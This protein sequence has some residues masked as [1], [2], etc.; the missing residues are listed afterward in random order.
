MKGPITLTFQ[1]IRSPVPIEFADFYHTQMSLYRLLMYTALIVL[2]TQPVSNLQ[3]DVI[4]RNSFGLHVHGVKNGNPWP[5]VPFGFIRLWDSNTTWREI[6]PEKGSW[7]FQVLD[8]YVQL[9]ENAGVEVLLTLGQTPAW[10]ALNPLSPSPYAAGASSPPR[11]F[12]D[13][14]EYV[15]ALA[16]RYKGRIRH[17]EVWNEINVKHFWSG[18]Y[19][20]MVRMEQIAAVAFKSVDPDNFL[21]SPSIQGGGYNMLAKYFA[22]GGGYYAD[23]V[24]YHFYAPKNEPEV[25][26]DR[27]QRVREIMKRYGLKNKPLWNTEMGWLLANRDGGFGRRQRPEWKDWRKVVY[28]ETAGF[29]MRAYLIN[30]ANGIDHIFW[31]A[32]NNGAMGLAEDGGRIIKPGALSYARLYSWLE[33]VSLEECS[34]Y[35]GVW[36][37]KLKRGIQSQYIL[38]SQSKHSF[39]VPN[40]WG[41]NQ[42]MRMNGITSALG[43]TSKLFIGPEPVLLFKG[44]P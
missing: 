43:L 2:I 33:G 13:W 30:M 1:P 25:L 37:V 15:I 26:G 22:A 4:H 14:R 39:Q 21:L 6:E 38:W 42:L 17:W 18:D 41:V 10:A 9:A 35:Q 34:E 16:K 27:I 12:D 28:H 20:T 29:V 44:D 19:T 7:R 8:R 5:K 31:Y 24:S 32:W 3:A 40:G 23:G 36:F 11:N